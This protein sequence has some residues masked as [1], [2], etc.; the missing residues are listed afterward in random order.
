MQYNT[1]MYGKASKYQPAV[2]G[3]NIDKIESLK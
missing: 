2:N 1:Q 3:D